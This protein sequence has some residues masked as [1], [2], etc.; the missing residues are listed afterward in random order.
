MVSLKDPP[1][2]VRNSKKIEK[3]IKVRKKILLK[4]LANGTIDEG[5]VF[6]GAIDPRLNSQ[7]FSSFREALV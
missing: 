5:T 1:L 3:D 2:F 7:A 4:V 6:W